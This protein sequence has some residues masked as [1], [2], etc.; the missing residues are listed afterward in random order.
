[1]NNNSTLFYEYT[2]CGK[3]KTNELSDLLFDSTYFD[4]VYVELNK[5]DIKISSNIINL[6]LEESL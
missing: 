3:N 1:M 2:M 4:K 5:I 6:I